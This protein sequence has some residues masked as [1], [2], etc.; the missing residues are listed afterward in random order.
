M[1]FSAKSIKAVNLSL[2]KVMEGQGGALDL[3]EAAQHIV[4]FTAAL[5]VVNRVDQ[6]PVYL[7]DSYPDGA[8]KDAVQCYIRSTYVLNPF[9]NAFLAGLPPG[10][11]RMI[12]LAP[13][14]WKRFDDLPEAV[15]AQKEEI[16]FRTRGWPEN[17]QE[18]ILAVDLP[19]GMMGEV[20]LAR[21]SDLGGFEPTIVER[22]RPFYPLFATSFRQM[23]ANHSNN[24]A[25]LIEPHAPLEDFAKDILS[26]REAETVQLILKGH[27][28][29][30]ISLVLGIAVPTV[31]T[32][33][34]NAYAKLGI[35]T[36][37][38][39]LNTFLQWHGHDL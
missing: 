29:L 24:T 1:D 33:R 13:D 30:S 6:S 5:C 12:D 36:Q 21:P 2:S 23:W 38:Q 32:H 28:S 9:Y 14:N 31:K 39:L 8:P 10:L 34:K 37:Q 27:S 4:P 26:P 7:C 19:N 16:G 20:S 3:I 11:H 22:F 35:S 25:I 18:L 15:L 17:L